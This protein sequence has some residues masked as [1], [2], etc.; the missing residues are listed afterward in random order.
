MPMIYCSTVSLSCQIIGTTYA[1][2]QVRQ[3]ISVQ[4]TLA[5]KDLNCITIPVVPMTKEAIFAPSSLP[6]YIGSKITTDTSPISQATAIQEPKTENM[7]T[8]I[9]IIPHAL[10]HISASLALV[11]MGCILLHALSDWQMPPFSFLE[12]C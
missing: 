4:V 2:C 3:T 6:S 8:P 7:G 11:S 10:H 5:P 12:S 1:S 9:S